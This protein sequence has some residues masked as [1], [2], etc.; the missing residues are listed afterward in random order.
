MAGGW[1][2]AGACA[3]P[4]H[5][6][7]A[8]PRAWGA[9]G[10]QLSAPRRRAASGRACHAL[11]A[12]Q[13][14]GLAGPSRP[15]CHCACQ[16]RAWRSRCTKGPCAAARTVSLPGAPPGS[17]SSPASARLFWPSQPCLSSSCGHRRGSAGCVCMALRVRKRAHAPPCAPRAHLPDPGPPR[18][19]L[20][21]ADHAGV[22]QADVHAPCLW[23][24]VVWDCTL[25]CGAL[26][27]G[28]TS[29]LRRQ[30]RHGATRRSSSSSGRGRTGDGRHAAG[31]AGGAHPGCPLNGSQHCVHVSAARIAFGGSLAGHAR[32]HTRSAHTH[33]NARED[34]C[35]ACARGGSSGPA[36]SPHW[37]QAHAHA[38]A[39]PHA[40]ART[41]R[42]PRHA[43]TRRPRPLAHHGMAAAVAAAAAAA[44]A[45]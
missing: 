40:L 21:V 4:V 15:A 12:Q 39:R 9:H 18:P 22:R 30:H 45:P 20:A 33:A 3:K 8:A 7:P 25:L 31:H 29:C 5:G 23:Q 6:A 34:R 41:P 28:A 24:A 1:R 37:Q 17:C 36:R 44:C 11:L 38:A 26:A 2:G 43:R 16:A 13:A 19:H 35:A 42:C 32:K 27:T 14:G 10:V